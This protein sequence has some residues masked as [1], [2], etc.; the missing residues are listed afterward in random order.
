MKGGREAKLSNAALHKVVRDAVVAA[1]PE[2]AEESDGSD[3]FSEEY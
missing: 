2:S 1:A 3:G